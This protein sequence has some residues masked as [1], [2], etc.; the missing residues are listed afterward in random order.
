MSKRLYFAYALAVANGVWETLGPNMHV[1]TTT[2]QKQ[3]W[4]GSNY[5]PRRSRAAN[6]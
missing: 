6:R 3:K 4:R 2:W 5:D 1:F